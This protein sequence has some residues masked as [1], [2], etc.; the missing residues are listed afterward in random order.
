[1]IFYYQGEFMSFGCSFFGCRYPEH[2]S[3][4]LKKMADSGFSTI[5]ITYSENDYFFYTDTIMR[6]C[7]IA[8]NAG[9]TVYIDP[10]AVLGI[11]GGESFSK[12]LLD[13]P[14]IWQ[15]TNENKRVGHACINDPLTKELLMK[16]LESAAKSSADYIFW[17]EPH[18]YFKN[19]QESTGVWGCTCEICRNKFKLKYGYELPEKINDDFIN[20]RSESIT[21]LLDELC[22]VAAQKLK[23]NNI[24]LLPTEDTAMGGLANWDYIKKIKNAHILSTDPYWQRKNKNVKEYV[25]YYT[26]KLVNLA[27][28]MK[29]GV[30]VWVQA[31]KI[32]EGRE[33]EVTQAVDLLKSKNVDSVMF[34]S[35]KAG[36]P[37]SALES[38][39]Y[40]KTWNIICDSV[41]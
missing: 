38:Y 9:F 17:D 23:K 18:F 3:Y 31:Y 27:D 28:E 39:D 7:D 36:Y 29:C 2:F 41:K 35:Y 8:K 24:C 10:W 6:M 13:Y 5:L 25:G 26:D 33:N 40:K 30:E 16:W 15:L 11:F 20:F 32:I 34:W 1:M 37:M 4:E 22:S 14:E 21:A 12:W 19:F